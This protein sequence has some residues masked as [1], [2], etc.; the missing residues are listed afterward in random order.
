MCVLTFNTYTGTHTHTHTCAQVASH[1]SLTGGLQLQEAH[2]ARDGTRKLIFALVP[3]E[4]QAS[5]TVETV[6]MQGESCADLGSSTTLT[7]DCT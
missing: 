5:G 2:T 7:P 1:A 3:E 6:R 4:G